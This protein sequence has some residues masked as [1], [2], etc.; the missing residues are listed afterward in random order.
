MFYRI[1]SQENGKI[2]ENLNNVPE[3]LIEEKVRVLDFFKSLFVLKVIFY[4][5][6]RKESISIVYK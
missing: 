2:A 4:Q 5:K 1:L 3:Q 6:I